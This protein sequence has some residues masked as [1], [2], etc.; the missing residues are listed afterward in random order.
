[1]GRLDLRV[2]FLIHHFLI[3]HRNY[4]GIDMAIDHGA[5]D[6]DDDEHDTVDEHNTDGEH[7]DQDHRRNREER[8]PRKRWATE[9]DE[10]A[11]NL[12]RARNLNE[13]DLAIAVAPE[14]DADVASHAA[15]VATRIGAGRGRAMD[16]CD[17]GI[18][19]RRMPKLLGPCRSGAWPLWHLTKIADAIVA[20]SDEH[21]SDVEDK[22][23]EYLTPRRDFQALPGIR[24]F[25]R[26]LRRIV[27]AI[28]PVSTPPDEGDAQ[29]ITGESYT[30]D[31]E[32][33]GDYGELRAILR[34]DRLAEFDATVRAIRESKIKDGHECSLADALMSMCRGDFAG[35]TVTLN[36]YADG[37][38]GEND[39]RLWLDGAGWLPKYVTRQWLERADN[40]RLS[41]DSCTGGYVPTD[42]QKARVR[43]RDGGCRFPG[44]EVP[45]HR[46]Q[47]DHVI[48]FGPGETATWNLQCLCQH[49]HNM[50]TSRH[51]HAEMNPDGTVTWADHAGEVCATTVPHGP[52]AHIK[53]QSFDQRSTRLTRTIRAAN[54]AKIRAA[55]EAAAD[56]AANIAGETQSGE[57]D[58][59]R[60]AHLDDL[61]ANSP[62]KKSEEWSDDWDDEWD[63]WKAAGYPDLG[64]DTDAW[65]EWAGPWDYEP[66]NNDPEAMARLCEIDPALRMN[67]GNVRGS[68]VPKEG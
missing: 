47:L 56:R 21:L 38:A 30:A 19:L 13:L 36:V 60:E 3:H 55:A 54:H 68:R 12:A 5:F 29:P 52:I 39:L 35:A 4:G 51:W 40:A 48:N 17:V 43:A 6:D 2:S 61:W 18:M 49:H 15:S 53:R 33:P 66:E 63:E 27:E 14:G 62:A 24:V 64:D 28:E 57:A 11:T 58:A 10:P 67:P 65:D 7:D 16:Y 45:A 25:T 9:R 8:A 22:F 50:K 42:A 44:C 41:A 46:C 34:K 1:M 37:N 32:Y 31:N 20:V 59:A 26:E 23:L